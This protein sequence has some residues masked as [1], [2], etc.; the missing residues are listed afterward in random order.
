[1]LVRV[2]S[3]SVIRGIRTKLDGSHPI[4]IN[5]LYDEIGLA[6][7]KSRVQFVDAFL[8]QLECLFVSHFAW[9]IIAIH[10]TQTKV[11]SDTLASIIDLLQ[12]PQIIQPVQTGALVL[13]VVSAEQHVALKGTASEGR[14]EFAA[15]EVGLRL[16]AE[17]QTVVAELVELQ[18]LGHVVGKVDHVAIGS[19]NRHGTGFGQSRDLVEIG[20]VDQDT[21]GSVHL[22]RGEN[23][24][25][26]I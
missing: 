20:L 11:G 9:Q 6:G 26:N 18:I 19:R 21:I 1:M 4:F 25:L 12:R 17:R 15:A 7:K 24:C 23:H 13:G 8:N 10:G 2:P 14:R 5:A 3:H 22:I 16:G